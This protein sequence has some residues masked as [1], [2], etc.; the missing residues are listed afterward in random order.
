M[1]IGLLVGSTLHPLAGAAGVSERVHSSAGDFILAPVADKQI[2]RKVRA[3]NATALDRGNLLHSVSFS[4]TRIFDSAA[5]AWLWA[6]DYDA[7]FPREGILQMD[8]VTAGGAILRRRLSNAVVSPPRRR[9]IGRSVLLDYQVDGSAITESAVT[10]GRVIVAGAVGGL[11]DGTYEMG[12]LSSDKMSYY[13]GSNAILWIPSGAGYWA[14]SPAGGGSVAMKSTS[15]VETPDL[16]S[17]WVKTSDASTV[18]GF[19]VT[20]EL[21]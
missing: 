13:L 8:A 9:V 16:A 3:G 14:F 21:A 20:A 4:T 17:D 11:G 7:T 19:T 1:R 2:V 10:T 6:L 12:G 18:S 5:E 15:D